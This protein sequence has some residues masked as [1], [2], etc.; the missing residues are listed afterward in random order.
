MPPAPAD[1]RLG[2]LLRIGSLCSEAGIED[3]GGERV[4][5]GSATEN[6]LVQAALDAG[7]DVLGLRRDY[8]QCSMQHRTEAYRFMASVH[9]YGTD[10]LTAVKGSPDEVLARCRWEALPDGGSRTLTAERRATIL[11]TNE[12]LA[13]DALRV[14]GF[15]YRVSREG[16]EAERVDDLIWVGLVG[17]ADPVRPG[18]MPLM[19]QLHRAGLQTIMLTGDQSATAR[20]VGERVGLNGHSSDS[21]GL[22]VLDPADLERLTEAE[23]GPAL[24]RAHAVARVS[25]AQKLAVVQDLQRSGATVVMVGDGVNDSPALR[26][27]DV[28]IAL[29]Q[30]GPPAAREVADIFLES[31]DPRA[32][33]FALDRGRATAAN[34]RKAIHYLLSTN[35]SEILLML[36]ATAA[37]VGGALADPAPL[38]QPDL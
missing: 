38:D 6:A 26:A 22:H 36:L 23:R 30:D 21:P 31:D 3:R 18:L 1:A 13:Q 32:L 25:P 9:A 34:I 17:L 2:Q 33:L 8:A 10:L 5:T 24:R 20:A 14:L 11:T 12:R 15:A 19:G 27:S 29:G 37:G 35:A 7:I 28:G 16:E 4:L